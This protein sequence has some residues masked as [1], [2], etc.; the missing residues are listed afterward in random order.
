MSIQDIKTGLPNRLHSRESLEEGL[1]SFKLMSYVEYLSN[2]FRYDLL[3][4]H[5]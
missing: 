5:K 1:R 3:E 2:Q 4:P